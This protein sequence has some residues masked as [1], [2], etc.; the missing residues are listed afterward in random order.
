MG[1]AMQTAQTSP[2]NWVAPNEFHPERFLPAGHPLRDSRFDDDDREAY[3]PF[4]IGTRNCIGG[5]CVAPV[6]C[7]PLSDC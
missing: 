7:R 4:S 2:R 3:K 6:I 1:I 5:K